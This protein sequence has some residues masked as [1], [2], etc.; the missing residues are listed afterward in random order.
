MKSTVCITLDKGLINQLEEIAKIEDRSL[1]SLLR[2]AGRLY[3]DRFNKPTTSK[4]AK[5]ASRK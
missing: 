2:I 1:S 3:L 4:P 5:K